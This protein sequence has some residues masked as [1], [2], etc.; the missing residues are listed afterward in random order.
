MST[1][2]KILI[3]SFIAS[4]AKRCKGKQMT[5][6][7]K[8]PQR[9]TKSGAND[10]V[11]LFFKAAGVWGAFKCLCWGARCLI[12]C[13]KEFRNQSSMCQD[14]VTFSSWYEWSCKYSQSYISH[15]ATRQSLLLDP[16]CRVIAPIF[17]T[18]QPQFVTG[19]T[20]GS[21]RRCYT[22]WVVLLMITELNLY[23]MYK[24]SRV[25]L[26]VTPYL[27]GQCGLLYS[28]C[29]KPHICSFPSAVCYKSGFRDVCLQ[30]STQ[31]STKT[32]ELHRGGSWKGPF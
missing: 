13:P 1:V 28:Y 19:V 2:N 15:N 22:D 4:P 30:F 14:T 26:Q 29:Q 31:V 18:Q 6:E 11:V 27:W 21:I 23:K 20:L 17:Q 16:P 7:T 9:E 32:F 12:I 5:T 25:S 8:R 10:A 24:I 3:F